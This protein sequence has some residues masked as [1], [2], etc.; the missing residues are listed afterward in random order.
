MPRGQKA[1]I[2][3]S[4]RAQAG[5]VLKQLEEQ[6]HNL[7]AEVAHLKDQAETWRRAVG[8][9][10]ASTLGVKRG[11]G[12]PP[13]RPVGSGGGRKKGP[14]VIW[15]EVLASVPNRF[16]VLDVMKH[17]GAAAK[18]RAQV[19]PALNR[20]EATKRIKRVEQGVYEKV[21]GGASA[22]SSAPTKR[23]PGKKRAAA[24]KGSSSL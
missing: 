19:Y 3:S 21:G 22:G 24:K 5:K 23:G 2:F 10:I 13:G 14:R 8:G 4:L 9:K 12:R 11:P 20:W 18:G 7:E 6:I 15:D 16:G 1:D 17:P